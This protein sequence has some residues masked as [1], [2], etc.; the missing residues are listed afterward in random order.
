[1][2]LAGAARKLGR[3]FANRTFGVLEIRRSSVE[4]NRANGPLSGASSSRF[5]REAWPRAPPPPPLLLPD[6]RAKLGAR[7]SPKTLESHDVKGPS[8][9]RAALLGFTLLALSAAR[10]ASA[11]EPYVD[12]SAVGNARPVCGF[13]NPEDLASLPGDEVLLVSEYGAMQGGH[14]GALVLFVLE[15]DERK[16]LYRGGGGASPSPGWGD[17]ACPGEPSAEFSPH[18]IDLFER[19]DGKLALLV[20][21]HGG[22]ESIEWFEVSGK[23]TSWELAWRGCILAP[24]DAWLNEVV[25]LPDGS[26][27]TTKMMSRAGGME[28]IEQPPTEPTGN[29][30]HWSAAE[31][32]SVVPGSRAMMPNGIE[33]SPDGKTIYL[34]VTMESQVRK[35]DRA[36]GEIQARAEVPMPDNVTWSPDGSRLLVA[37]LRNTDPESFEGCEELEQGSCP[38]A[39]AI[40]AV[41]PET[42][43][44]TDVYD[45]SGPPMGAGTVGLQV[46]DEIF[47]GSFKG[48]RVLRVKLVD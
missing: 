21:Q 17:P 22:R 30:Y 25:G 6:E 37:S 1:M 11:L 9:H 47:V 42:M 12:C 39:F 8:M 7:S 13:Q 26:L 14:A 38:L 28:Q 33:V 29:A 34:N 41:D 31:G 36:S 18:G 15:G 10:P 3:G 24:E 32:Y 2:V 23:G 48:D 27:L 46:G 20:V 44:A 35:I 16:P 4:E 5:V 19:P 40:V 43:Q 45:G